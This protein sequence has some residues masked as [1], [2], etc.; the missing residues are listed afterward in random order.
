MSLTQEQLLRR[1]AD[2]RVHSGT[3][4]AA[5]FGVTRAAV[6][7]CIQ[8]LQ[9]LGVEIHAGAGRG[10]QLAQPLELLSAAAIQAAVPEALRGNCESFEVLWSIRSTNDRLLDLPV[11]EPG[12]SRVCLAEFQ[13]GGRGRRGRKWFAPAGAGL[14]LSVSWS[15]RSSPPQLACLGLVAGVGVLRAMRAAGATGAQLKWPN[16]L[17]VEGRKLAGILI[18]VRGEAGGPLQAVVGVGLNYDLPDAAIADIVA[19]GGLR[20]AAFSESGGRA[21]RNALAAALVTEL[22]SVMNEFAAS[23]FVALAD[24]WRA[25]DYLQGKSVEVATDSEALAGTVRGIAADGRLQLQTAAGIIHLSTGDV[26]VRL[27]A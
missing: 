9:E 24:E 3:K 4:L 20:P 15:F 17:V 25:A 12:R 6:W 7:K 11:V 18:D 13:S 16:D 27:A 21:G 2:G 14:C 5:G 1:L 19:A 10:Y 23:G 22:H 26:S 8:Q